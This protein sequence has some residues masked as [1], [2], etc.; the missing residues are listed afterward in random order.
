MWRRILPVLPG[1]LLTTSLAG[2]DGA[3]DLSYLQAS[4]GLET[5]A[6]DGGR[7]EIEFGD[8]NNDGNVD[9]VCVGDHGSPFINTNEHGVMVW[10]GDGAGGWSVHQYGNFGY[11]GVAL[12]DVN[13]DGFLDVGYGIHHDY[14]GVDL[15]DQLLEVALGDGT[16]LLWTAWDDSL[17]TSGETW[18][19]FGTDFADVDNDGDL[20][21][22]SISFG[23]CNGLRVYLNEGDGTWSHAWSVDGGNSDEDFVFGDVNG[24]GNADLAASHDAG[25]VYL[26]DGAGGFELAD[27]DLP[28][29]PYRR[30]VDLGDVD[31]D[32]RDD[33]ACRTSGGVGVYTM[34]APGQW[35]DRSGDLA[36]I[37]EVNLTQIADMNL[38]G[39]GDVVAFSEEL[40]RIYLGDGSG[41]W[42]LGATIP[43]A[44]ACDYAA[45]RAGAD[46]DHNG[47][48][49]FA[50]I[51][52]E[53]CSIFVGGTNTL[54]AFVEASE[55]DAPAIHAVSPRGG[56]QWISGSVRFIDWHAAVPTGRGAATVSIE[57][58]TSGPDG[59]YEPIAVAIPNNGRH[60][61]LIPPQT[62]TS[63]TCHL[64]LTLNTDPPAEVI[65]PAAF[66][67]VNPNGTPGDLNGDGT[68]NVLDLLELLGTW[69]PCPPR[70][71]P[72][73]LNGDGTVNVLDLLILLDN[74]G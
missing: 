3:R 13:N 16:G 49:D 55:P 51:A 7:T 36:S 4:T 41:G 56:E 57:L 34:T 70:E 61:W 60:Q 8:V 2:A 31:G 62:P 15:G 69:G 27:G 53:D 54:H 52:E 48:P 17:A 42:T 44:D 40:V 21:V 37:G 38:D 50:F 5:P 58:S 29:G 32:G 74:W 39:H 14:S 65:T 23:C 46:V 63:E 26:G 9:L 66:A 47:F 12:G 20:D 71:C 6:L 18:G 28:G 45:F 24:D 33:L 25:T 11:G 22:G 67:I 64:R 19:M 72:A 35:Q 73:D 43:T 59:P 68:V 30:G 1:M 10:F